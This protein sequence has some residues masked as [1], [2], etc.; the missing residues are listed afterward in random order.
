MKK[1]KIWGLLLVIAFLWMQ[2]DPVYAQI[3]LK[4]LEYDVYITQQGDAQVKLL[5]KSVQDDTGTENYIPINNLGGSEIENFRVSEKGTPYRENPNWDTGLSRQEK[6]G[7]YGVIPTQDGVE[8][9]WGIGEPGTHEYHLE[10]TITNLV[11][12]LQD[13]QF[14]HW[15][16]VNHEMSNP[17]ESVLIRI[18]A[19][20]PIGFEN[21]DI[22][23]FG[24]LGEVNYEEGAIVM[25]SR[26]PFYSSNFITLLVKFEPGRFLPRI[27]DGRSWHEVEQEALK[28]S[29]Y[30]DAGYPE[31]WD[32][33]IPE[34]TY[35]GG[36]PRGLM[37][38]VQGIIGM[39]M[40]SIPVI[41]IGFIVV[42]LVSG[43][44]TEKIRIRAYRREYEGEFEGE[45]PLPKDLT[46]S[47]YLLNRMG[48]TG[49][50]ELIAAWLLKWIEEGRVEQEETNDG[51]VYGSLHPKI[52]IPQYPRIPDGHEGQLFSFMLEAA[53]EDLV[54]SPEEFEKFG[55]SY[56]VELR[57]WEKE[58][59]EESRN[60]AIAAG[61]Y[62]RENEKK[63]PV[64]TQKGRQLEEKVHKHYNFLYDFSRLEVLEGAQASLWD[65]L[66][67]TAALFGILERVEESFSEVDTHYRSESLF[68][69]NTILWA[70]L[71]ASTV[72]NSYYP[73]HTGSSSNDS[74]GGG[75]GGGMS[76][77]GG[78]GGSFGGGG[79]GGTR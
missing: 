31:E 75:G 77:M 51:T 25:R 24:Y 63:K 52:R 10:Y 42:A 57:K 2:P 30:G 28:G 34:Q 65:K 14:I 64:I 16:F 54:L 71:Y 66:I 12:N 8:L 18:H 6:S 46:D 21:T 5:W 53:G 50:D 40:S 45:N 26:D 78:G 1:T 67:I 11:R 15:Q 37:I 43:Q 56:H 38:G 20:D 79:G 74:S 29:D 73:A 60:R 41:V 62:E 33:P 76:S 69:P 19:D 49:M 61:L 22:W 27:E 47:F 44:K 9:V 58:F 48:I 4:S 23:A 55:K 17:P 7:E 59:F 70:H 32:G 13:S 3:T 68:M 39:I 36:F 72:R 35:T